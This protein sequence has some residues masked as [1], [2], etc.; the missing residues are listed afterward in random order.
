VVLCLPPQRSRNATVTS[1]LRAICSSPAGSASTRGSD[2]PTG[3]SW[4]IDYHPTVALHPPWRNRHVPTCR[5]PAP[6]HAPDLSTT[7]TH[8]HIALPPHLR[9]TRSPFV[10]S[11]C[12]KFRALLGT[13]RLGTV[14]ISLLRNSLA[15]STYAN[16]DCALRHFFSFCAAEGPTPLNATLTTMVRYTAWLGMLGTVAASSM[17]PYFSAV[18]K[19]FCDH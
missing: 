14:T 8:M 3:T 11:T 13:D 12:T 15:P 7:N 2:H 17:Q 6:R 9:H 4:S 16:Y 10:S 5:S 18:N 1:F 19:Y